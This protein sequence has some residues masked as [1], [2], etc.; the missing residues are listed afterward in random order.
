MNK[1][2]IDEIIQ[3]LKNLGDDEKA[4]AVQKLR[5]KYLEL[6]GEWRGLQHRPY[7]IHIHTNKEIE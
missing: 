3:V 6:R 1:A 2:I 5:D 4:K 7:E